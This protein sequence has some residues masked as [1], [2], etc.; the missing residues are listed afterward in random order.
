MSLFD[1]LGGK[2]PASVQQQ[3]PQEL[4]RKLQADPAAMLRQAG[5]SIPGGMRDPQQIVQHLMQ[6]GQV[7][8]NRLTQAMQMLGRMGGRR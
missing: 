8:Q 4:L 6:T 7:P 1:S 3:N 5:L 2:N